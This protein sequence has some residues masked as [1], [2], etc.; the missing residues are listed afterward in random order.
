[1]STEVH[2][3]LGCDKHRKSHLR[4]VEKDIRHVGDDSFWVVRE[5]YS[6]GCSTRPRRVAGDPSVARAIGGSDTFEIRPGH[7]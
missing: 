2:V 3:S 5:V 4:Y 1:M 7:F 6:C